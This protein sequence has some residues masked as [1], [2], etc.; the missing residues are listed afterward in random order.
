M[1]DPMR[2]EETVI[3]NNPQ[4]LKDFYEGHKN[5][6]F[7]FFNGRHY[8]QYIFKGI[9]CGFDPKDINDFIIVRGRQGWEY[10][11]LFRDI[12]LNIFDVMTTFHGL[13]TLEGFMGNDIRETGV[14]FNIDRKLTTEEI[15]ETIKYCRH[16]VQQTIEIFLKRKDDFDAHMGMIKMFNLP[17]KYVSKTKVQLS[18][19]ILNARKQHRDD[20]F[21]LEYPYTLK[22]ERYTDVLKWYDEN[23]DYDKQLNIDIAGV[24]HIFAWGGLHG[25]R[26]NYIGEG[27]FLGMDVISYYPS[28]KIKYGWSSRN[29]PDSKQYEQIYHQRLKY[30]AEENPLQAPL[31][32][33]LNGTYGAMK[34]KYNPLYDPRQA[35]NVCVGGQLLLLDLIEKL[36]PYCDIIQSNTDG[37]LVKLRNNR[38]VVEKIAHE[39]E[40]RTGMVLEFDEYVK[41][42]QRDV[43]N[44]ILVPSGS[45]YDEKGKPRWK[46]KGAVV[47]KLNSLDY[48][49]AIVNDAVVNYFIKSTPVE[50]TINSCDDLIKFQKIVKVSSKFDYAM[51]GDKPLSGKTFRV[52]ASTK[53]TD[54]AVTKVKDGHNPHKFSNTSLNSFIIN[55][56]VNGMK[57]PSYLDKQFYIDLAKTRIKQFEGK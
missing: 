26:Q 15:A 5:D 57:A 25:A 29:I 4:K 39:W 51:H 53:P 35:N 55:E 42:I 8:D 23:R 41:V 7:V 10:S 32:I 1:I 36:E 3:V 54:G 14:D 46:A 27:D 2:R 9:L 24:P 30:K 37:I 12:E 19:V 38:A 43:N 49:M 18:A 56:N 28:L 11:D 20:E 48:D 16:D 34:D 22:L 21:D 47:K 52:F 45:L 50:V 6:I 44:Y 40:Q 33:V 17:L 31:K 13:K